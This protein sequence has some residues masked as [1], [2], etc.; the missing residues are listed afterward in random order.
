MASGS[1]GIRSDRNASPLETGQ[2]LE[3]WHRS[4]VIHTNAGSVP[5]EMSP[6]RSSSGTTWAQRLAT[7]EM[8]VKY[9]KG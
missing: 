4:G 7:F 6:S 3:S 2:S 9:G 5:P 1:L 8:S